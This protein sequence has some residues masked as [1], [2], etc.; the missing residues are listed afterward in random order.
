MLNYF[1]EFYKS[2]SYNYSFKSEGIKYYCF[3]YF[4]KNY[5]MNY[6]LYKKDNSWHAILDNYENE[7]SD[8]I[9]SMKSKKETKKLLI[10]W[11]HE[12]VD[13]DGVEKLINGY[14]IYPNFPEMMLSVY[15][16]LIGYHITSSD[17]HNSICDYGLIPN[18]SEDLD[19]R[20]ASIEIDKCKP[21]YIPIIRE[22][23]NYLWPQMTNYCLG[24]ERKNQNLYVINIKNVEKC[25]VGSQGIGGCCIYWGEDQTKEENEISLNNNKRNKIF[26]TYWKA[27]CSL[28]K[29][30]KNSFWVRRK[31][32]YWGL[33]EILVNYTISSKDIK[34]IG[35]WDN[36]GIFHEEIDF[37]NYIKLEHRENYR[38]ILIKYKE[39]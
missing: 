5:E 18:E 39:N 37:I 24:S 21:F 2:V 17:Y 38:E 31:D 23:S 13:N 1:K 6:E 4:Y 8:I 32:K 7:N 30:L 27:S 12:L 25:W 19:I 35:C 33:D 29:Y 11:F 22:E 3:K 28:K 16:N 15:D 10:D 20:K 26:K 9:F 36:L 14:K 34:L